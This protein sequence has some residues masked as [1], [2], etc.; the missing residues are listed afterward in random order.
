[1]AY[2]GTRSGRWL[3]INE[4]SIPMYERGRDRG[5]LCR[6]D[7]GTERI[8]AIR[9]IIRG[10]TKSC[11]CASRE[12]SS[13]RN[14]THGAHKTKLYGVWRSMKERCQNPKSS[15]YP[16]YGGRGIKVCKRWQ[17][18]IAFQ[19]DN[20]HLYKDGLTLDRRNNNGHY[21][22]HNCRWVP[23]SV[24][25]VN[26]SDNHFL[27]FAGERLTISQWALKVGIKEITLRKRIHAG[28]NTKKALT[29]PVRQYG[30]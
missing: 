30:T 20:Q 13:I 14:R 8:V 5:A 16:R 3:V 28:W 11:G 10:Y 17:K 21:S 23:M 29:F 19:A 6:C 25:F 9:C 15:H 2:I 26:R 24:Q 27:S 4:P 1:M 12:A 7:C 22:P 18:F